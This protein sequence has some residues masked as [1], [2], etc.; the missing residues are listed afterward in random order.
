MRAAPKFILELSRERTQILHDI[1]FGKLKL[2]DLRYK[3]QRDFKKD[4]ML[5]TS[6]YLSNSY[7]AKDEL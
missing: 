6:H 1:F 5:W 4:I 3:E 7:V 2:D